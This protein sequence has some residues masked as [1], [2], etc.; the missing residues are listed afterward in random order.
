V[1]LARMSGRSLPASP[2]VVR[3]PL[4]NAFYVLSLWFAASGDSSLVAPL[5]GELRKART[6]P[7]Q[8]TPE[9]LQWIDHT[10]VG[11]LAYGRRHWQEAAHELGVVA[12]QE[13]DP[14]DGAGA[15][16]LVAAWFAADAHEQLG[17]SDSASFYLERIVAPRT[18]YHDGEAGALGLFYSF[19]ERRLV[20]LYVKLGKLPEARERWN[21]F[22]GTCTQPDPDLVPSIEETRAALIAAEAMAR[23]ARK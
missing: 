19:A 16:E 14:G 4:G 22:T 17:R 9:S 12:G 7:V 20:T 3:G 2:P 10:C 1:L 13:R 6:H 11:F 23:M 18:R 21:T 15:T 8:E 5:A